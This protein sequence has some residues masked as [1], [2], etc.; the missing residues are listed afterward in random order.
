MLAEG[1]EEETVAN[2]FYTAKPV[3]RLDKCLSR[4]GD[5]TEE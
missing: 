1:E 2:R 4:N 3:Q 5:C